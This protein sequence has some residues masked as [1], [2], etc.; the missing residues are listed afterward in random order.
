MLV[1]LRG[2]WKDHP[3]WVNPDHVK[4]LRPA[5]ALEGTYGNKK[6]FC[7][8]GQTL[9]E[10]AVYAGEGEIHSDTAWGTLDEVAEQINAALRKM[11]G[12]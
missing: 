8:A 2:T 4:T 10:Y 1:K 12:E 3:I 9:I 6:Q 5:M 11:E 7:V